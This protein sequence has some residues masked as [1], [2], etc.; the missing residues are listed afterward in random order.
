MMVSDQTK[1]KLYFLTAVFSLI[2]SLLGFSYNAW[3][4]EVSEDNSNVREAAF[5]V[6][7]ELGEL[8]QIVYALHYD[9]DQENGSPRRGWVKI[10]LIL[11]LSLLISPDAQSSATQLK[12]TWSKQ[13][14]SIEQDQT[15]NDL[16]IK[17]I[18]VTRGKVKQ[19]LMA[20]Q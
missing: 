17:K 13:W 4:M 20:L 15:A 2:F 8:E 9:H 19:A 16:V 1:L 14:E 12:Q 5:E 6:L 11:D 18:E 3:R 7:K 10:G